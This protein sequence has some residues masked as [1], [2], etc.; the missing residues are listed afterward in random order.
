M[1]EFADD[2]VKS[3]RRRHG[4]DFAAAWHLVDRYG[5]RAADVC[6]YLETRPDLAAPVVEGFP[7]LSVE[8]LYQRDEEM[9]LR[10]ADYLLRRTRLGLVRPELLA[11]VCEAHEGPTTFEIEGE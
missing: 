5:R 8:F 11:S 7:D 6:R 2:A 9:A 3:L 10:P 4:L 1:A